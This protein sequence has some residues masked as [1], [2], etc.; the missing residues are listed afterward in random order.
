MN[1]KIVIQCASKKTEGAGGLKD[2]Y[3]VGWLNVFL[4]FI[5]VIIFLDLRG[6]EICY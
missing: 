6:D 1:M 3:C 5:N 4:E 2:A